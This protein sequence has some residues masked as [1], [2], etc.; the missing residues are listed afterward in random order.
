MTFGIW[1][2]YNGVKAKKLKI[3]FVRLTECTNVTDRQTDAQ[4]LHDGICISIESRGKKNDMIRQKGA[5]RKPITTLGT[6]PI[7]RMSDA[8]N[9]TTPNTITSEH[10]DTHKPGRAVTSY[11][12]LTSGQ[13]EFHTVSLRQRQPTYVCIVDEVCL[14]Q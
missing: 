12:D 5:Y 2:Y 13:L 10:G 3:M 9:T 11:D 1:K 14:Q 4:T 7:D 6:W 8:R